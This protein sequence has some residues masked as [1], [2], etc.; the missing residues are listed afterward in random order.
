M[1]KA[2]RFTFLLVVYLDFRG[3]LDN[4]SSLDAVMQFLRDLRCRCWHEWHVVRVQ[5][6]LL[7]FGGQRHRYCPS[8]M[9]KLIVS[10]L[11]E[12]LDSIVFTDFRRISNLHP[13]WDP[14]RW[15][16][17]WSFEDYQC[18]SWDV[19]NH[20]AG[21]INVSEVAVAARWQNREFEG[22]QFVQFRGGKDQYIRLDYE[23][24]C[25]SGRRPAELIVVF[26]DDKIANVECVEAL[27]WQLAGM[28]ICS[29]KA[30]RRVGDDGSLLSRICREV[31]TR[32][33]VAA[34]MFSMISGV[35]AC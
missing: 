7:C 12:F 24:W 19:V 30:D 29:I 5:I 23:Y 9:T 33:R 15:V 2:P 20:V 28:N 13:Y 10:G 32:L 18:P 3:V 35:V 1:P 27:E 25:G 8:N 4:W 34:G 17:W 11:A 16:H 22:R 21:E 26:V 6:R 31:D 14:Q